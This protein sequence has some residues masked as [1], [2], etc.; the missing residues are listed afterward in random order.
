MAMEES[1][2]L[3]WHR[4]KL[5]LSIMSDAFLQ[6]VFDHILGR[7]VVHKLM[8]AFSDGN[9]NGFEEGEDKPMLVVKKSGDGPGITALLNRQLQ[10]EHAPLLRAAPK[11]ANC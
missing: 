1:R 4:D 8:Q 11:P 7:D 9:G 10:G 2:V 5:K 6:A 3:V